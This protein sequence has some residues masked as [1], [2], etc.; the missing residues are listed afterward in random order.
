[1]PDMC[2]TGEAAKFTTA[3]PVHKF[4][5]QQGKWAC[6]LCGGGGHC[7]SGSVCNLLQHINTKMH[8]KALEALEETPPQKS[9]GEGEDKVKGKGKVD[10][11]DKG[12]VDGQD[13][14]KVDEAC[15]KVFE[16]EEKVC[17]VIV[18]GFELTVKKVVE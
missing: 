6:G 4:T 12:K 1:M 16:G 3:N 5:Y 13:T 2:F 9:K 17:K 10:E 14:G 8:K 7:T 18:G 11:E 15:R